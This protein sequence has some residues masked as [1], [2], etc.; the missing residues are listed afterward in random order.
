MVALPPALMLS[1]MVLIGIFAG[2]LGLIL[3]TPIL[4]AIIVIVQELYVKDYLER[5][6]QIHTLEDSFAKSE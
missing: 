2:I 3:A 6:V 5:S 1:W 4:A